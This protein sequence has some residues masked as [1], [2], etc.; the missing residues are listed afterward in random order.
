MTTTLTLV[1]HLHENGTPRIDHELT[2]E[3]E[4]P[5]GASRLATQIAADLEQCLARVK[6]ANQEGK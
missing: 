3:T 6:G 5:T 4:A 2:I 1:V